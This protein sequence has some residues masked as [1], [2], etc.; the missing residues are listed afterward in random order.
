M[1]DHNVTTSPGQ[2]NSNLVVWR[3][4]AQEEA[5]RQL[6]VMVLIIK[7]K[8]QKSFV[9]IKIVRIQFIQSLQHH[10]YCNI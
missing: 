3:V 7:A 6:Y 8:I 2:I 10:K 1:F 4:K 9:M 5:T